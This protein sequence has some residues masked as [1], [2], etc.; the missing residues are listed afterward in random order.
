MVALLAPWV[1][2]P[3]QAKILRKSYG[4]SRWINKGLFHSSTRIVSILLVLTRAYTW[5][6]AYV[7]YV[8]MGGT[9]VQRAY[10]VMK[11]RLAKMP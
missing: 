1:R 6:M 7:G 2:I 4:I 9:P 11:T 5:I 3:S 10:M 8:T